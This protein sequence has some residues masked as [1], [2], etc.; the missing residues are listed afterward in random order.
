MPVLH[1]GSLPTEA[2]KTSHPSLSRR[3]THLKISQGPCLLHQARSRTSGTGPFNGP[4]AM[5]EKRPE[6][7]APFEESRLRSSLLQFRSQV[8][9]QDSFRPV[10]IDFQLPLISCCEGF[11]RTTLRT[12]CPEISWPLNRFFDELI[13][14]RSR[15]GMA[16]VE[17]D[18]EL[19]ESSLPAVAPASASAAGGGRRRPGR[20]TVSLGKCPHARAARR[21]SSSSR[22]RGGP[23][24]RRC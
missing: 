24:A 5:R 1:P 16:A 11:I 18:A 10:R 22:R 17:E 7:R 21:R 3:T 15:E 19:V 8:D 12:P 4:P 14:L 20:A 2:D 23:P 13:G 6:V 9:L